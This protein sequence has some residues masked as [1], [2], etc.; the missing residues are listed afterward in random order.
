MPLTSEDLNAIRQ[1]MQYELDK[2]M[3]PLAETI[4]FLPTKD[5]F[6]KLMDDW[7]VE[8]KEYKQERVLLSSRVSNHEERLTVIETVLPDKPPHE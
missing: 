7:I 3:T 8:V 6:Y 5:E 1:L 4:A 2:R